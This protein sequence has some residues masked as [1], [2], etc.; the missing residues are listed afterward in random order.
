MW[1]DNASDIDILFYNPYAQIIA[2]IAKN[3][4]YNPLTIGVFGAWGAGKSTLLNLIKHYIE[5]E[6]TDGKIICVTINAWAFE[7]YED[8]KTAIIEALLR[9][10]RE[11]A[12]TDKI[13]NKLKKL[14]KRVDLF[15]LG[16]KAIATVAPIA[17]SVVT[18]TPLPM[19]LSVGGNA[20]EMGET[21]K[22]AAIG[23]QQ[24]KDE[25]WKEEEK[26]DNS[27][28]N[29]IR[30]F[31]KEFCDAISDKEISNVVIMLDDLDRCQP[32]RIIETLEAVK[33]FLSVKKTTFIIA[34][35]EDIIKYAIRKKYPPLGNMAND[36]DREYIEKIIQLPI[37]IPELSEK[38]IQNYLLLLVAQSYLD[39]E[40]FRKLI[41]K[42][43]EEKLTISG[44]ILSVDKIS[45]IVKE[46]GITWYGEREKGFLDVGHIIEGINPIIATT[47]KGNP[48]QAKRFLNT[49]ITKRR[50]SQ[51]YYGEDLDMRILAKLL[52]LQKLDSDLFIQLN[53]WNRAFDTE[54]SGFK[55][56][57][58]SV[59]QNE[60]ASEF[61][62]WRRPEIKKWIE[63]PPVEL[64]T[65]RLD[66]YFY[67]TRENLK[68][69]SVDESMLSEKVRTL[70]E[71]IG[72]ATSGLMPNIIADI[73]VLSTEETSDLMKVLLSKIEESKLQL[74]VVKSLYVG[75]KDYRG[76]I[77]EALCKWNQKIKLGDEPLLRAMYQADSRPL[78]KTLRKLLDNN[79]E[80]Q[81]MLA[82]IPL[83]SIFLDYQGL[84]VVLI[85][86]LI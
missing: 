66:K 61:G 30:I 26:E 47:L 50:L 36:L 25:Y 76:K 32:D 70:L 84:R 74:F 27:V 39:V 79:E 15:K 69:S 72:K 73:Q 37:Y 81:S 8:A 11:L 3:K 33:L 7:S 23:L 29:N 16:T 17:A 54:N 53:D 56:M 20:E 38:D 19:L 48:R 49:F 10:I 31:Q 12:P 82:D 28:V 24:M 85:F 43:T 68:K 78:E 63:C 46:V 13:R 59:S 67:L 21:I 71:R 57:R 42:L 51:I 40:G 58:H 45:T 2:D 5:D 44:D 77:S 1:L 52:V 55:N 62:L 14:L 18:G 65:Q 9:E 34:A 64:E 6:K 35:D 83:T 22:N 75:L 86:Y 80:G 41:E 4:D 60:D